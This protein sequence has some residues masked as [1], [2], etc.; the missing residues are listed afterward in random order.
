MNFLARELAGASVV[1]GLYLAVIGAAEVLRRSGRLAAEPSRKLVHVSGGLISLLLPALIES[2]VTVL[3]LAVGTSALLAWTQRTARLSSLHGVAR[4]TSGTAYYPLAVFLVFFLS[5][6]RSGLYV[7]ALLVLAVADALAALVGS[8]YGLVRYQVDRES[9]SLEGSLAFLVAAFLAI[10]LPMLLLTDLPRPICVLSALLVATLVTGFEAVSLRGTDNLFVPIGVCV[11]LPKITAKPLAEVVYQNLSLFGIA[12]IVA[13]IAANV[14]SFDFA[15]VLMV[16]LFTYGAWSLGSEL[17]ALPIFAGFIAYVAATV[18]WPLLDEGQA[19]ARVRV[20]FRAFVLPFL[21]VVIGNTLDA[22]RTMYGPFLAASTVVLTFGL[23]NHLLRRR[24]R[25]P[26]WRRSRSL[27][28]G[29]LAWGTVGVPA[30]LACSGSSPLCLAVLALLVLPIALAND[31]RLGETPRLD[32]EE[33][34]WDAG[35]MLMTAAAAIAVLVLQA[36]SLAPSWV[37]P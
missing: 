28:C 21:L 23:W 9:K 8:R 27:A 34:R 35:R 26:G 12:L 1:A 14:R 30:W 11:I 7:S 25:A 37:L 33:H 18:G 6:G 31:L 32:D 22:A 4:R 13:V 2:S 3:A 29:L 19:R 5:R 20:L 16:V 15:G 17:W 10:H 24:S 36:A